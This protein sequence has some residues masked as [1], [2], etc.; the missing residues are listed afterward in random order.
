MCLF[1]VSTYY[2]GAIYVDDIMC[3]KYQMPTAK[4]LIQVE[5][6][7]NA[8]SENTKSIMMK[9]SE[10]ILLSSKCGHFVKELFSWY[11]ISSCKC[12][13]SIPCVYKVLEC[14]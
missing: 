9:K 14:S 8:L 13:L 4:A 6:A 1:N 12:T 2:L 5:F 7:V 11:R 3:T 10:K